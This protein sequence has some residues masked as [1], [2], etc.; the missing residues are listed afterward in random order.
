L[1][2][3]G[4]IKTSKVSLKSVLKNVGII[5]YSNA[6][7]INIVVTDKALVHHI[8]YEDKKEKAVKEVATFIT[9][10]NLLAYATELGSI[11]FDELKNENVGYWDYIGF[12]GDKICF[13]ARG[14]SSKKKGWHVKEF[15]SKAKFTGEQFLEAP[16]EYITVQNIGFG[17]TGKYYIDDRDTEDK[18][19]VS[20]INDTFYMVGGERENAAARLILHEW[21]EGEWT[22]INRMELNYFIEKKPLK[23]GL[24]PMNEGIGYHLDHNG[25]NKASIIT[26]E[27]REISAHNTFTERTIYNPSSVFNRKEKQEFMVTLPGVVLTFDTEQLDKK[28]PVKFLMEK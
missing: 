13:A 2:I 12:T 15:S 18:G 5:D 21:K 4:N 10:H 24:Y 1:N 23:L 8:R 19:M 3:A 9:H 28:G 22:E 7:V 11:P 17:T 6:E 16:K 14:L 25:Y 27:K 26:F 20:Y